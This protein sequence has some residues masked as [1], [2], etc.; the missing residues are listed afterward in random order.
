M[1]QEHKLDPRKE[2]SFIY[3]FDKFLEDRTPFL[4]KKTYNQYYSMRNLLVKY[5]RDQKTILT[6]LN[7]KKDSFIWFLKFLIE[8]QNKKE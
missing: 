8:K 6:T 1:T 5:Q 4:D 7:F 2:K 3:M